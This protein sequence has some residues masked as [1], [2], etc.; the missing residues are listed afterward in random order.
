[1]PGA[2]FAIGDRVV[3]NDG[4]PIMEVVSVRA[5]GPGRTAVY[6]ATNAAGHRV[7]KKVLAV[8]VTKIAPITREQR[9]ARFEAPDPEHH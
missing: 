2:G 5:A 7:V 3:R 4:G 1:M 6:C 8:H 9:P